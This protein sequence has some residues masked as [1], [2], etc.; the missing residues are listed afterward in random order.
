MIIHDI[1]TQWFTPVKMFWK[2]QLHSTE[3]N[4]GV[5]A[6]KKEMYIPG[7][8]HEGDRN[9]WHNKKSRRKWVSE[10]NCSRHLFRYLFLPENLPSDA[11]FSNLQELIILF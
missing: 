3:E 5:Q 4:Q 9:N 8:Q 7:S 2:L 6:L 10:E 11:F 1:S